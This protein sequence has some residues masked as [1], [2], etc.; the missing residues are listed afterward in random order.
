MDVAIT[1][2]VSPAIGRCELGFLERV[3]IDF[4]LA[5]EQHH[6]YTRLMEGLGLEVVRLPADP[7]LPDCCFV[8]DVAIVLDELAIITRPGSPTRRGEVEAVAG[9]LA[10][11]RRLERIA[12]PGRLDGGDVL[13]MGRRLY[14]GRSLRTDEAGIRA[15]RAIVSAYGY[16]VVPVTVK[17]CLHL[18]TAVTALD[19][20]TILAN[21]DWCDLGP[22]SALETLR[23]APSEP[24]AANVLRVRGTLVVAAGFPR[25][26]ERLARLGHDVRAVELGELLKAE[27]GVTCESLIFGRRE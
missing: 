5:V 17:G 24:F 2:E 21:P 15:L 10:P 18:K 19:D 12:V 4:D 25:T 20:T 8:E 13:V 16:E 7:E 3:P 14:V 11:H 27:A 26:C 9:A 1:R 6:A 22:L 23:V